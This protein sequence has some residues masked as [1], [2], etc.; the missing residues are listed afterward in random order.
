MKIPPFELYAET[1][2]QRIMK[3]PLSMSCD[4]TAALGLS[5]SHVMKDSCPLSMSCDENSMSCDEIV[6]GG[7]RPNST[8]REGVWDRDMTIDSTLQSAYQRQCSI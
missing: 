8:R 2:S 6:S 1:S 5:A 3:L 7:G 4:K